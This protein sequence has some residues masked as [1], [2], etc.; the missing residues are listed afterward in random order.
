MY[1]L[2]RFCLQIIRFEHNNINVQTVNRWED[3]YVVA[4]SAENSLAHAHTTSVSNILSLASQRSERSAHTSQPIK[5]T[6]R[7]CQHLVLR[8]ATE[9]MVSQLSTAISVF[10]VPFSFHW[11]VPAV[12][13]SP[14]T[15]PCSYVVGRFKEKRKRPKYSC[16]TLL[17]KRKS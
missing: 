11:L 17:E 12:H 15:A 10:S 6:S 9:S 4:H 14:I 1:L 5:S 3:V 7:A 16:I 13:P 2:A 8:R